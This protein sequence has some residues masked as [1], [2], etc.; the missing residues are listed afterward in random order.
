MIE[1]IFTFSHEEMPLHLE[2]SVTL[3]INNKNLLICRCSKINDFY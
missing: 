3:V 1:L 2:I